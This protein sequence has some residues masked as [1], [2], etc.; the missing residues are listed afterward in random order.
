M[1]SGRVAEA[2]LP[3]GWLG[4]LETSCTAIERVAGQGP[5]TA[6]IS[7]CPGLDVAE[8]LRHLG[9]VHRLVRRWVLDGH[10][11]AVPR[12]PAPR[13]T[14]DDETRQWFAAGWRPLLETLTRLDPAAETS[15]WCSYDSTAAF[16]WRRMAHETAIHA[17][18]LHDAL[19]EDW[20]V[21]DDIAAD[22]VDEALRLWLGTQVGP[23]V[24]GAGQV[25]RLVAG[26]RF[27]T[28]GMNEHNV[29]VNRLP[30]A[31]GATVTGAPNVLYR[32][33]WG[34]A[35]DDAITI[36]GDQA[37]VATLRATLTHTMK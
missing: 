25:I 14:S 18:D 35:T 36:D 29:E 26:S 1:S 13:P 4:S 27:W 28:V 37:A 17:A 33:L 20:S 15:T 24:F 22:G 19:G 16:W 2:K 30:I 5:L 10:R 8:V 31:A 21:P 11:P 32:W 6:E 34:R 7:W 23:N 9:V 12:L 3:A